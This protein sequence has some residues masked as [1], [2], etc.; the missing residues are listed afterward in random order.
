MRGN[1]ARRLNHNLFLLASTRTCLEA[2]PK[3]LFP[4]THSCFLCYVHALIHAGSCSLL[5]NWLCYLSRISCLFYSTLFC[6]CL[7]P[8]PSLGGEC[9]GGESRRDEAVASP[10]LGF[11]PPISSS[12]LVVGPFATSPV[13]SRGWPEGGLARGAPRTTQDRPVP[14]EGRVRGPRR[15]TRVTPVARRLTKDRTCH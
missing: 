8:K 2:M 3:K 4:P 12:Q 14:V 6:I 7:S 10:R 13:Q 1:H 9:R 5:F 11:P 15:A